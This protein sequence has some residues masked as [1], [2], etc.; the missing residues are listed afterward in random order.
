[1]RRRSSAT[2]RPTISTSSGCSDSCGGIDHRGESDGSWPLCTQCL[3]RLFQCAPGG[4]DIVHQDQP[5]HMEGDVS[6]RRRTKEAW[7]FSHDPLPAVIACQ[8]AS[9]S[10]PAKHL[11]HRHARDSVPAF[12]KA[13]ALIVAA[14]PMSSPVKGNGH[15]CPIGQVLQSAVFKEFKGHGAAQQASQAGVSPVFEGVDETPF[16][17]PGHFEPC[18]SPGPPQSSAEPV[19]WR[20][21]CPRPSECTRN[22]PARLGAVEG[23]SAGGT[24][25]WNHSRGEGMQKGV[26]G[27]N[28]RNTGFG[29]RPVLV[30]NRFSLW[31]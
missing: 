18:V 31:M 24:P 23:S 4:D 13:Q 29:P 22:A 15:H 28:G 3:M 27:S 10:Y 9:G 17:L 12:R 2:I 30:V 14:F 25:P 11:K 16:L 26:H 21:G 5:F 19:Q 8:G 6:V 20:S 1:M 7:R